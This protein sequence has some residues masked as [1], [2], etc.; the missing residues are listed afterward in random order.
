M[1]KP[2]WVPPDLFRLVLL[3]PGG[4]SLSEARRKP[5]RQR[6]KRGARAEGRAAAEVEAEGGE[7]GRHVRRERPHLCLV[8]LFF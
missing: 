8:E 2:R 1:T 5:R 4:H 7:P 6:G 3:A